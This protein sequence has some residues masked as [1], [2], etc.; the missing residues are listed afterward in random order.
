[1]LRKILC[2][3]LLVYFCVWFPT[4]YK[5]W[6]HSFRLSKCLV[7]RTFHPEW[8][9][10]PLV[11]EKQGEICEILQQPFSYLSK[12]KQSYVF[13]SQ[14]QEYVLKLFY[15]DMSRI[16]LGQ[17]CLRK[18]REWLQLEEI[19][20]RASSFKFARN[21]TACKLAYE[22][23]QKQ[24]GVVFVHLNPR[25]VGL[26]IINVKDRLGIKH[27]IDPT[28]YRFAL[29]KKGEPFQFILSQD[30]KEPMIESYFSL[31]KEIASLGLVNEDLHFEKNYGF[32]DGRA[33]LL[34]FG[35]LSLH[36][37]RAQSQAA[38]FAKKLG[39]W[40]GKKGFKPNVI[41]ESVFMDVCQ[42]EPL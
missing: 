37:D 6:T 3:V 41:Q 7:D 22:L 24:T 4:A 13:V 26:P 12:G 38:F 20:E 34:D 27:Q 33:V 32:M 19:Q 14:D 30:N 23:A 40:L 31:L 8:E 10:E 28:L 15:F 18:I 35:N 36:P 29:Q 11:S 16:Q 17:N 39:L 21:F 5:R 9:I 25:L 2:L 42:A 1:M